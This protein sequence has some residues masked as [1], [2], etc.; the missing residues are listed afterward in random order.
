MFPIIDSQHYFC[1][2]LTNPIASQLDLA[3]PKEVESSKHTKYLV[4]IPITPKPKNVPNIQKTPKR[5][6]TQH[7]RC[8][9][10]VAYLLWKLKASSFWEQF[11]IIVYGFF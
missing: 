8:Q 3:E 9:K 1:V 4:P 11:F 7:I 5:V 2:F 10:W 6:G